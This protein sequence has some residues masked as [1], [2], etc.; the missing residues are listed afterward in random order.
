M[1]TL[2]FACFSTVILFCMCVFGAET[3]IQKCI[4]SKTKDGR[5]T[6]WFRIINKEGKEQVSIVAFNGNLSKEQC[7]VEAEKIK[8]V[9]AADS[10]LDTK[11]IE[12]YEELSDIDTK[13]I[14]DP[15]AQ[16]A[17]EKIIARLLED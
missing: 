10:I 2:C 12:Q 15:A 6:A 5:T 9:I 16:T 13:K 17:I 8:D 4:K 7:L 14:K 11:S 1:R 3:K